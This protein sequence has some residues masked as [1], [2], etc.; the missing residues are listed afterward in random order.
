MGRTG[1]TNMKKLM[2]LVLAVCML[3]AS[4]AAFAEAVVLQD[5]KAPE[6]V[7]KVANGNVVY[8]TAYDAAGAATEITDKTQI[9]LIDIS[10]REEG[11]ALMAAAAT[12]GDFSAKGMVVVEKFYLNVAGADTVEAVFALLD[13]QNVTTAFV[14]TNGTDWASADLIV[15]NDGTVTLKTV[16]GVVAFTSVP[17]PAAEVPTLTE[18]IEHSHFTSSVAAKPAPSISGVVIDD[19]EGNSIKAPVVGIELVV[20]PVSA[21]LYVE[22]INIYDSLSNAF[23]G[24]LAAKSLAELG[25][26][27]AENL[28][29]R[30]LFEVTL[31]GDSLHAGSF[32]LKVTFETE[33]PAAVAVK[34]AEGWKLVAN[35]NIVDNGNGTVTVTLNELG[36]VAFLTETVA[37]SAVTSPET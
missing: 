30:D 26:D 15:N 16:P 4:T 33:A 11:D 22:D 10:A 1:G 37:Q 19:G 14:T 23:K 28:V 6:I 2:T 8:A 32:N 5:E 3:L 18:T 29:V 27:G 25:I 21:R 35:E 36:T 12:S 20:T 13:W 17:A 9:T 7:G 31:Y 24:I 34:G